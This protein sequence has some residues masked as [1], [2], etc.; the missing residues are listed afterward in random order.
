MGVLCLFYI[1]TVCTSISRRAGT[2]VVLQYIRDF[3]HSAN[4]VQMDKNYNREDWSFI[5]I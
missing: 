4:R 5:H 2:I 3:T 1:S